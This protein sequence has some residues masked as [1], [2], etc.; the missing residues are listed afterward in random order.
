MK[1]LIAVDYLGVSNAIVIRFSFWY[2]LTHILYKSTCS[3][4]F[5]SQWHW[6]WSVY[7]NDAVSSF[8]Y[9]VFLYFSTQSKKVVL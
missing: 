2:L 8:C 6:P 1:T 7:L 9:S 4:T 3:K 5:Q